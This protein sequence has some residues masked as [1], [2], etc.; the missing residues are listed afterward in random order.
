VRNEGGNCSKF[1]DIRERAE[2]V[3]LINV[4]LPPLKVHKK[5]KVPQ[6]VRRKRSPKRKLCRLFLDLDLVHCFIMTFIFVVNLYCSAT[7]SSETFDTTTSA[8]LSIESQLRNGTSHTGTIARHLF[9]RGI[10]RD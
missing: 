1:V 7:G 2:V 8:I 10:Y 3:Y 9:P 6:K 4:E 5:H